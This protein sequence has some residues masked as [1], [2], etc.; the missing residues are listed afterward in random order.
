MCDVILQMLDNAALLFEHKPD[1]ITNGN[2]T[3]QI[4]VINYW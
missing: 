1:Q 3:Y 2:Y 4:A